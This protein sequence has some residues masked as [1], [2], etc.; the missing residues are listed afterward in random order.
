MSCPTLQLYLLR[1]V[2]YKQK[3]P[4]FSGHTPWKA[5]CRGLHYSLRSR[6]DWGSSELRS[7]F[8]RIHSRWEGSWDLNPGSRTVVLELRPAV[9]TV[10]RASWE[11][12]NVF[13]LEARGCALSVPFE[14][15]LRRERRRLEAGKPVT[16]PGER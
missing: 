3:Q 16:R 7:N 6:Y 13:L 1:L 15:A 9:L 12:L 11:L 10:S 2:F 8:L 14:M 4:L 5:L